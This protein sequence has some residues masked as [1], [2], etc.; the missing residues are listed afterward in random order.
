M[1]ILP[2][3]TAAAAPGYFRPITGSVRA[4]PLD[5]AGAHGGCYRADRG[6]QRSN[7]RYDGVTE[8]DNDVGNRDGADITGEPCVHFSCFARS[9]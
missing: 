6:T 3:V 9:L 7:V 4:R 1:G 5:Y 8:A 2:D